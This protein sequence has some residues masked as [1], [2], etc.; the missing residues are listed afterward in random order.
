MNI[1]RILFSCLI[2]AF[3]SQSC[4]ILFCFSEGKK[5]RTFFS[6]ILSS[7]PLWFWR[8]SS[9][10][11]APSLPTDLFYRKVV[12]A[13]SVEV[14]LGRG[15]WRHRAPWSG[16]EPVAVVEGRGEEGLHQGREEALHGGVGRPWPGG[17]RSPGFSPEQLSR[18]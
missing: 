7:F 16:G 12:L 2:F 4:F 13:A 3:Q 6:P 15:R 18:W 17:G 10:P 8:F 5:F 14:G 9:G 1:N 11:E